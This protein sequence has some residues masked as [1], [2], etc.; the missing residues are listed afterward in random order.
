M[1]ILSNIDFDSN[2][3]FRPAW[4]IK[5]VSSAYEIVPATDEFIF[6]NASA[7]SFSVSLPSAIG[8]NGI[9][10]T[11]KKVDNTSN[12]ITVLPVN[13]ETIDGNSQQII[14]NKNALKIVSDGSNW[15]V[16]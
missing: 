10:Y 13:P 1:K 7:G 3:L 9:G 4:S 6:C 12:P 11:I 2:S 15:Y 5:T 16:V 14:K 8:I